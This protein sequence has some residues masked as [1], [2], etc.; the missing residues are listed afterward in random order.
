MSRHCFALL[1]STL[2]LLQSAR[3]AAEV[4]TPQQAA[5]A[6]LDGMASYSHKEP[7][8]EAISD[9]FLGY[10][11]DG[12]PHVAVALRSFK[13]YEKVTAMV[14]VREKDGAFVVERADIPDAAT[15]KATDKREKVTGAIQAITGKTVR[16]AS[17]EA[18]GIDA[19]TGA[20]RYQARIYASFDLMV[21]AALAEL[22]ANPEWPRTALATPATGVP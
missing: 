20:T 12:K 6:A 10:D 4:S 22:D 14:V 8:S 19:A 15:I 3:G 11:A 18:S 9:L 16:T 1:V 7:Y 5:L 21:K 17:G 2:C 13:T